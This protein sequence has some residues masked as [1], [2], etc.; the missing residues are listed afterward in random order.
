MPHSL[1]FNNVQGLYGPGTKVL[2]KSLVK[3]NNVLRI[4]QTLV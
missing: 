4:H 2:V 1:I 3:E